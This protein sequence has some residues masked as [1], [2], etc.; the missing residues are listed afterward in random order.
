MTPMRAIRLRCLDCCGGSAAEVKM[1]PCVDCASWTLRFGRAPA[2]VRKRL[3]HLLDPVY[4]LLAGAVLD[5]PDSA[6]ARLA[7]S[8]PR[9]V[10][11]GRLAGFSDARI[12]AVVAT[13]R[14]T[15]S[16]RLFA[17]AVRRSA[18]GQN[19]FAKLAEAG[20]HAAPNVSQPPDD[21]GAVPASDA[22]SDAIPCGVEAPDR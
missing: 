7:L 16:E 18:G 6:W 17:G 22:A 13:I 5:E 10:L 4:V 2:T 9:R 1:C 12:A 21:L 20:V 3:P 8:A 15:P 19:P 11:G 14:A